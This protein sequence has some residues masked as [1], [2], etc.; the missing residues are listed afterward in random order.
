MSLSGKTVAI[1]R[2]IEQAEELSRLIVKHGGVPYVVP[3]V[4]ITPV[5]NGQL[6][7]LVHLITRGEVSYVIFMSRNGAK[8]MLQHGSKQ[9]IVKGLSKTNIVAVGP[10]TREF[11]QQQGVRVNI[12]PRSF[13]SEGVLEALSGENMRGKLVVIPRSSEGNPILKKSLQKRGARVMEFPVYQIQIPKDRS[14]IKQFIGKLTSGKIDIIT[15]TSSSAVR[16][17]FKVV[18]EDGSS[19][20]V[21]QF[22]REKVRVAVIGPVTR[23]TIKKFGIEP[24]VMPRDFTVESMVNALVKPENF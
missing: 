12:V 15:F 21:I 22:L 4:Q 9:T 14:E 13:T 19:S 2:P 8:A 16:N 10:K 17:F 24:D 5:K 11:L 3:T 20:Q 6:R 7:K 18:A 23:A 1:T